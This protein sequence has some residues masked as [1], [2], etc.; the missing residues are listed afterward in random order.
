MARQGCRRLPGRAALQGAWKLNG[1][2]RH[3]LGRAANRFDQMSEKDEMMKE[4]IESIEGLKIPRR[5]RIAI[6][7]MQGYLADADFGAGVEE[8]AQWAVKH[9]DAL[10]A[11]LDK[12]EEE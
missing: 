1:R 3:A 10:I 6:A 12:E 9:A 2:P 8:T 4:L 11:E 5:E 7:A